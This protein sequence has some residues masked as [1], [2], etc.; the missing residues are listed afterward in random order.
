MSKVETTGFNYFYEA[1]YAYPKLTQ[2][3]IEYLY[4]RENISGS[5]ENDGLTEKRLLKLIFD[6]KSNAVGNKENEENKAKLRLFKLPSKE[7]NFI[8]SSVGRMVIKKRTIPFP[9][10]ELIDKI[11]CGNLW[12]A[13]YYAKQ[14][15]YKCNKECELDD[16]VQ[17]ANEALVSAAKYY[18]P[19]NVAKF[20]T[21]ASTCIENSLKSKIW[22]KKKKNKKS[23]KT[24]FEQE[25]D[26][27]EY[28]KLFI[29]S[30][31]YYVDFCS[32]NRFNTGVKEHNYE[33]YMKGESAELYNRMNGKLKAELWKKC[34]MILQKSNMKHFIGDNELE[35]ARLWFNHI[36]VSTD[37]MEMKT[38]EYCIDWYFQKLNLMEM[39]LSAIAL[40]RKQN[41]DIEPPKEEIIK[42]IN[43]AIRSRNKLRFEYRKKPNFYNKKNI[44]KLAYEP[45]IFFYDIYER[46]YDIIVFTPEYD[47]EEE[48]AKIIEVRDYS[49]YAELSD[50]KYAELSDE[51]YANLIIKQRRARV[52]LLMKQ[53]NEK[54][55]T[56]N[57]EIAKLREIYFRGP[58][59]ERLIT[60]TNL[61]KIESNLK[62]LHEVEP[63]AFNLT[64]NNMGTRKVVNSHSA[65]EEAL[66]N[67]FS[68]DYCEA[69]ET[70]PEMEADVMRR[71]FDANGNHCSTAKEV[72]KQLGLTDKKVYRLKEKA[73]SLLRTNPKLISYHDEN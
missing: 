48:K 26:N 37:N 53:E 55:L 16:L 9:S 63:D 17:I 65:E 42:G 24:F 36:G 41:D 46:E 58:Q 34:S 5:T 18:I 25:R 73:L 11:V 60:E 35:I 62:V 43:D 66:I 52:N 39:Y 44:K 67:L 7:R 21:Y 20:T 30:T 32:V 22:P 29:Q 54:I 71:Y 69:L 3:E 2:E 31:K 59:Y 28:V 15:Y 1:E 33:H 4:D 49:E 10:L 6:S 40:F 14:Y 12:L 72:G 64:Y 57:L 50:E 38:I 61:E 19:S 45:F 27:L 8:L 70:L 47:L 13:V 68:H 23:I 56:M 51:E